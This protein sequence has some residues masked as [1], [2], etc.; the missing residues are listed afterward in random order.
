M[1]PRRPE[2]ARL[3]AAARCVLLLL[4]AVRRV[5]ML[6]AATRRVLLSGF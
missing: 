2:P 3:L 5:L 6:L 4:A 1:R